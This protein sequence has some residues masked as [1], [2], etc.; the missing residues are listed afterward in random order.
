M[1][2]TPLDRAHAGMEAAPADDAARLRFFGHLARAELFLLL[3]SE[4]QDETVVPRTY[5]FD[6]ETYVAAF[7]TEERL[8]A[9]ADAIAPWV[10]LSGRT[11]A[12]MLSE[13]KLGLFL[14]PE[15]APSSMVLP[16]DAIAWLAAALPDG[17]AETEARPVSVAPPA[18][19]APAALDALDAALATAVGLARQAWLVAVAY[20]DGREGHLLAFVDAVP[21][22]EPG[23][24]RLVGEALAFSGFASG[25][26]DVVFL[27]ASD[28]VMARIGKVGLRFDLPEPEQA[29]APVA[30]GSDPDR[31]PRLR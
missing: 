7:D 11:L 17:P 20:A 1:A 23:L 3:D 22:A 13:E 31:P 26:I 14:N 9:F 29:A 25:E 8:T 19:I 5:P 30:P 12:S 16:P 15:V 27:R 6:G 21:G 18:D 28:P 24:A 10:A 4:A 2:D